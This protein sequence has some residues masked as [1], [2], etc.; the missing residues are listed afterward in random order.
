MQK[1]EIGFADSG[2]PTTLVFD[3]PGEISQTGQPVQSFALPLLSRQGGSLVALPLHAIQ[4]NVLLDAGLQ[5]DDG[6]VGPSREF[7]ADLVVEDDTG[8]EV[9]LGVRQDFVV[10]DLAD[11]ALAMMREYMTRSPTLPRRFWASE[12]RGAIVWLRLVMSCRT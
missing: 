11:A 3:I 6:L 5:E 8:G 1:S 2:D 10:V 7:S 9:S 4:D 12:L